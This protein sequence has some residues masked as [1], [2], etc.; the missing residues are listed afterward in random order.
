MRVAAVIVVVCV[1]LLWFE[2]SVAS[3]VKQIE[4]AWLEFNVEASSAGKVLN[5]IINNLGYGGLIH[6]FK[7]YVLRK[8]P[9]LIPKIK[10]NLNNLFV[11]INQYDTLNISKEEKKA[12]LRLKSIISLYQLK[13]ES[14]QYFVAEGKTPQQID[15]NVQINDQP[16]FDAIGFLTSRALSRYQYK[17]YRTTT[18]LEETLLFQKIGSL[19]L[20]PLL[21]LI[22]G[23]FITFLRELGLANEEVEKSK[24][25]LQNV[26]SVSPDAMFIINHTGDIA[27]V[28]KK[29][30]DLFGYSADELI[31]QSVE[32]LMPKRFRKKHVMFRNSGFDKEDDRSMKGKQ[33]F[34]ALKKNGTEISIDIGLSF[35]EGVD[36]KQAIV[37]LR[38][39]TEKKIAEATLHRNQD[40]LNKAQRI[41]H[42]GSLEWDLVTNTV[43]WSDEVYRILGF[44]PQEVEATYDAF[45]ARI[46]PSDKE[47]MAKAINKAVE[48]NTP[49]SIEYRIV[50]PDGSEVLVHESGEVFKNDA[51]EALYMVCTVHDI[52]ERK[53]AEAELKLADNVFS[54]TDEAIIVTGADKKVLRINQ[55]FTVISGFS[56]KETV[57]KSPDELLK[58]GEHD[59]EFYHNIWACLSEQGMWEGEVIGRRKSGQLFPGWH[60]M[61]VVRDELGDII[62]YI[63]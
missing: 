59:D 33:E 8:D 45:L 25:Q 40:V 53:L 13:F 10:K 31:G 20:F 56:E 1:T 16:A 15:T 54:H 44:Q 39:I 14:S 17:E 30:S 48:N 43:K 7:N 21:L 2:T 11:G 63:S 52:T 22:G 46:I 4:S 41:A 57:G 49:Y 29:A 28:N 26:F 9:S 62:Q 12:L 34:I 19:I 5:E 24:Q 38:D 18:K 47:K 55:A 6:N 36:G 50:R 61:S 60:N 58:S 51:G 27:Q 23:L 3:R 35:F 32:M 37:I 42:L